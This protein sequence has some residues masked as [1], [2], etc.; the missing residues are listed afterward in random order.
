MT[1]S[2]GRISSDAHLQQLVLEELDW[3]KRV[4][5]GEISVSVQDGIV[6]LGGVVDAYSKRLAAEE[7]ALKV[8][9]VRAV[10]NELEVRPPSAAPGTDSELARIALTA[11]T[12]DAEIPSDTLDVVVSHG[13]VTLGGTVDVP[14]QRQ[15]AERLMHHLPGVRGV[16]NRIAVR[17]PAPTPR[18][19]GERIERALLRNAETDAERIRVQVTGDKVVLRGTVRSYAE[20]RAAEGAALTAPGIAEVANLLVVTPPL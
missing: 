11:L 4:A 16:V 6:T 18:D 19:V 13:W 15:E 12:W 9:G 1:S 8:L 2:S 3:D 17:L 14:F 10:A 20:R 5:Q 7:A